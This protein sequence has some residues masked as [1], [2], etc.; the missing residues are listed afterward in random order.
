MRRWRKGG[1]REENGG[2]EERNT[3]WIATPTPECDRHRERCDGQNRTRSGVV[4]V[5]EQ[6]VELSDR[7][8]RD[9]EHGVGEAPGCRAYPTERRLHGHTCESTTS[10][11]HAHLSFGIR[12]D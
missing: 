12:E 10:A 7:C 9:R 11:A 6:D 3:K 8:Q 1:L 4:V 5:R 2:N